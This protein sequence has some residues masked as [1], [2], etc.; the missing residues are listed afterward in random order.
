MIAGRPSIDH[1]RAR[2]ITHWT[3]FPDVRDTVE[4]RTSEDRFRCGVRR[5]SEITRQDPGMTPER[6]DRF[7]LIAE[8]A[9]SAIR[10]LGT[11]RALGPRCRIQW[12][13]GTSGRTC[14]ASVMD[15]RL[16]GR[17]WACRTNW[18]SG[19]TPLT[20]GPLAIATSLNFRRRRHGSRQIPRCP[21]DAQQ[22]D[23]FERR[24]DA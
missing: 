23:D 6:C 10:R 15:C 4:S 11:T 3:T 17:C 20:T 5:A 1:A 21:H 19:P 12:T 9:R 2:G 16:S 8:S 7:I 22:W 18:R 24:I 14:A 13:A